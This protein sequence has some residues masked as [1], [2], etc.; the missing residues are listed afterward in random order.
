[1]LLCKLKCHPELSEAKVPSQ[2]HRPDFDNG[3]VERI[4]TGGLHVNRD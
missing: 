2:A 1:M 3:I 4:E